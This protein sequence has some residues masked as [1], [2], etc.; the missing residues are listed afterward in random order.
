MAKGKY[1][2]WLTDDGL[3]LLQGWAR[4]GLTD[5]QIAHNIGI[6][7]KTLYEW[8]N[9]FSQIRE[10]L[11][12]GKAPVDLEVENALLKSALGYTVTLKKAIKVKTK[13]QLKDKGTIEEEHIEYVDEEVH[14]PAQ[15]PAQIFWLKNRRRDKWREKPEVEDNNVQANELL[16]SIYNVLSGGPDK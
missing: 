14:I 4:D 3:L 13:K 10:A 1:E 5:E 8:Q 12:K 15:V 9:R 2:Q 16:K 6:S 11:K 7:A